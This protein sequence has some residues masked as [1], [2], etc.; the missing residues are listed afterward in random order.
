[1]NLGLIM[2]D[3]AL[4]ILEGVLLK[5]KARPTCEGDIS[6]GLAHKS[7][8]FWDRAPN[9]LLRIRQD[10]A[11]DKTLNINPHSHIVHNLLAFQCKWRENSLQINIIEWRAKKLGKTFCLVLLNEE[12]ALL[13][14][15]TLRSE[16]SSPSSVAAIFA[17]SSS[18]SGR[19]LGASKACYTFES[20]GVL[21]RG[22]T[23][24]LPRDDR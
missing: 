12:I 3:T 16:E 17:I 11:K 20:D 19:H 14:L 23:W 24:C 22:S 4:F 13:K 5:E 7:F 2:L 15:V 18:G 6:L 10:L 1:M 21:K 8:V 9:S